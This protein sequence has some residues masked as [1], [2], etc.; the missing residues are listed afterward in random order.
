MNSKEEHT[1]RHDKDKGEERYL[2]TFGAGIEVVTTTRKPSFKIFFNTED[3]SCNNMQ[4]FLRSHLAPP[5]QRITQHHTQCTAFIQP[6]S[7]GFLDIAEVKVLLRER[8]KALSTAGSDS[9]GL[10]DG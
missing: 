10:E 1:W 8:L 2:D 4:S 9:W 5:F 3:K 7:Q 6:V